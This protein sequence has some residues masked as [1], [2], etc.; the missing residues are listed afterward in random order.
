MQMVIYG[1]QFQS[2]PPVRG[3][4]KRRMHIRRSFR[5]SIHSPR[6]GGD[7]TPPAFPVT[8]PIS[9]HSPRAGGDAGMPDNVKYYDISIHSPRAGGDILFVNNTPLLIISIHSP[10]AG[11]DRPRPG[12][13]FLYLYISIHSPRAGGDC[14]SNYGTNRRRYFNPLPPCGGR[15]SGKGYIHARAKFQSTPPVRGETG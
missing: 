12:I 4:T 13:R 15:R 9:I 10:R 11:G 6:A 5:I 2:T 7:P 14:P 8:A 3:E 1:Y